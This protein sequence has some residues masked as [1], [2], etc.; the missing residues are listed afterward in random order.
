[1]LRNRKLILGVDRLDYSKGIPERLEAFARL[2]E[3]YPQ[4]RGN[5]SFVQV[6]VPTRSEVPEYAELRSRVEAL[7]G[8]INGAFGEADW[9]PVRYLYR[10]YDQATLA[11]LYRLAAVGLVT[12]LCDG[13]N[14]VAKEY[15]AAQPEADPGVLV[16]SRFCGAAERM[17]LAM[18]T[19]PYHVDGVAADLDAAL[20]MPREDRVARNAALRVAVWEDTASAWAKT[21]LATLRDP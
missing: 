1:M 2:L 4:W 17:T 14:L 13:M 5:V 11:R 19:N 15:V 8:R 9:T 6:S 20:R 7:V 21:F 12:P 16:L 10:S 18:L 3:R